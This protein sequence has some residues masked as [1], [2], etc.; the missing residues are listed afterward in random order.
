MASTRNEAED[1]SEDPAAAGEAP[2]RCEAQ[3]G[4]YNPAEA[5]TRSKPQNGKITADAVRRRPAAAAS[6]PMRANRE[7]N[8]RLPV[9]D[10]PIATPSKK[11]RLSEEAKPMMPI[12]GEEV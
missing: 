3:D 6:T 4:S 5:P 12:E 8:N 1:G 7:K 9:P 2:I 10:P 11:P